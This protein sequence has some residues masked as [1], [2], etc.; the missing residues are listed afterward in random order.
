VE[1]SKSVQLIKDEIMK[2]LN[3]TAVQVSIELASDPGGQ[4]N[5][6]QLR[7]ENISSKLKNCAEAPVKQHRARELDIKIKDHCLN[8]IMRRAS[9]NTVIKTCRIHKKRMTRLGD[10]QL[11]WQRLKRE[12]RTQII[13]G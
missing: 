12:E 1:R 5:V 3:D 13:E 2:Y 9:G 7:I 10:P 4:K 8:I 6:S 11:L